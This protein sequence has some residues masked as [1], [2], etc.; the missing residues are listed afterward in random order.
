M[1]PCSLVQVDWR[2]KCAHCLH[3]NRLDDGGSMRFWNVCLLLQDYMA[4]YPTRLSCSYSQ[5]WQPELSL[6]V[7]SL[8]QFSTIHF[9]R[10]LLTLSWV[11]HIC[12]PYVYLQV[13]AGCF[14]ISLILSSFF[15]RERMEKKF[16]LCCLH[17][18]ISFSPETYKRDWWP[19]KVMSFPNIK[20][21]SSVII[22]SE[23]MLQC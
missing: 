14:P 7:R 18:F 16:H 3:H 10:M 4:P 23:S 12:R 20:I 19:E 6:S 8:I 15:L 9:I 5:M 2:F 21:L 13:P 22:R 11:T 17:T 1:A